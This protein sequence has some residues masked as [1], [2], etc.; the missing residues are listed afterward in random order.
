MVNL[1]PR[2]DVRRFRPMELWLFIKWTVKPIMVHTP[3]QPET[4][5]VVS[6]HK[7]YTS[8]SKVNNFF[9]IPPLYKNLVIL[10]SDMK[11]RKVIEAVARLLRGK[12]SPIRSFIGT[13][14]FWKRDRE[15]PGRILWKRKPFSQQLSFSA[16]IAKLWPRRAIS[17]PLLKN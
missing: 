5:R 15:K 1:C 16:F 9:L 13:R 14:R 10:S 17:R 4:N 7:P 11:D 12:V 2:I 6:T 3:A 8:K